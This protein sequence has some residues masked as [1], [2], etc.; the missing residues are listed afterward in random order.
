MS[1][2]LIRKINKKI[3][4]RRINLSIIIST[5]LMSVILLLL[6]MFLFM[7]GFH[8]LDTGYNI[9][10]LNTEF[11]L[12]IVDE[13]S[14]GDVLS[15]FEAYKLGHNQQKLSI[16]LLMV[17]GFLFGVSLTDLIYYSSYERFVKIR[18]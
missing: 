14:Q 5:L 4:K 3:N 12:N 11:G 7:N 9:R 16:Y 15:D 6:G 2:K 8:S 18:T 1:Q 17:G 13:T 10:Y